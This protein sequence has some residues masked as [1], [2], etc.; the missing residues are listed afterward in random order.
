M[1]V[2]L[3]ASLTW[4]P[5]LNGI[6]LVCVAAGVLFG[7][8]M[9][10]LMTNL[11]SRLGFHVAITAIFGWLTLMFFI[12]A[13]YGLG[14]KG[15][16]PAWQVVETSSTPH[17]AG[18]PRLRSIPTDLPDPSTYAATDKLVI[19]A[20]TG[21]KTAATMGDVVAADPKVAEQLKPKLNGWRLVASSNPINGDAAA[22]AGERLLAEGFGGLKFQSTSS[23]ITGTV[24][25]QGGKPH[26]KDASVMSR[27]THRIQTTAM[28][29]IGDNPPHYAVVQVRPT[30][31]QTALPG[32]PPPLPVA[33]PNQPVI[34]VLL[35]RN[36]GAIRQPGFA[37]GTLSLIIFALLAYQLHRRDKAGM[38]AR[39]AAELAARGV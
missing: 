18:D 10:L 3:L 30:I 39:H 5:G 17:A 16:A 21:R 15:P 24:F 8:P 23:F 29:F 19:Q 2:H 35:V 37:F 33:D 26:R 28:A 20:M 27:V 1:M 36:L 6:I 31:A 13:I 11:G 12:W 25:D 34:N 22:T 32:E 14:Y 38:A 9:I 7:T 4:D